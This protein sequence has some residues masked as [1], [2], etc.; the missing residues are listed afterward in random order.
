[1][2]IAS[3]S[4]SFCLKVLKIGSRTGS[5]GPVDVHADRKRQVNHVVGVDDLDVIDALVLAGTIL[6][7]I[8]VRA[9]HLEGTPVTPAP[10]REP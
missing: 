5:E 10:D 1:M 9:R 6:A 4:S 7:L 2:M 8:D 3:S